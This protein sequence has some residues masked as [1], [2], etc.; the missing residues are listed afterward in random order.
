MITAQVATDVKPQNIREGGPQRI[1]KHIQYDQ[2]HSHFF[3]SNCPKHSS[4]TVSKFQSSKQWYSKRG[5]GITS[6]RTENLIITFYF[7][8]LGTRYAMPIL[9]QRNEQWI[10]LV[11]EHKESEPVTFNHIPL[12]TPIQKSTKSRAKVGLCLHALT[13]NKLT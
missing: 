12:F 6:H 8:H 13:E 9:K 3:I 11:A 2:N 10:F 5:G 1:L 7:L 4:A